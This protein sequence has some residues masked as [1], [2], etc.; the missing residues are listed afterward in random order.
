MSTYLNFLQKQTS[1][2]N[3]LNDLL[4]LFDLTYVQLCYYATI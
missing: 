3:V 2:L 4:I 1:H